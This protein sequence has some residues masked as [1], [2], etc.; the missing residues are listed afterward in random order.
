MNLL[1]SSVKW[2]AGCDDDS[3]DGCTDDDSCDG[4]RVLECSRELEDA[5]VLDGSRE[6]RLVLECPRG[7]RSR[8]CRGSW[9]SWEWERERSEADRAVLRDWRGTVEVGTGL[10]LVKAREETRSL[11]RGRGSSWGGN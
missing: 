4:F 7:L 6:R 11:P 9:R 5:R 2:R 10:P 8:L 3:C 1:L